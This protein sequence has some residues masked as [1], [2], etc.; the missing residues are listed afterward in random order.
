[1]HLS[2]KDAGFEC[3]L[4]TDQSHA[5]TALQQQKT[6]KKWRNAFLVSLIFG[7]PVMATMIY[8]MV[9]KK[10]KEDLIL[11]PGL[12]VENLILFVF[13]SIV[14]VICW[15]INFLQILKKGIAKESLLTHL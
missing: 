9:N 7:L 3:K 10:Q 4:A 6:V 13:S 1:M 15:L 5:S 12:S 2:F 14:Q 11:L 8:F